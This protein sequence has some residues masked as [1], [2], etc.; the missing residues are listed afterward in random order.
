RGITMVRSKELSEA[1]KK[2]IVDAYESDLEKAYDKV[3]REE[4]WYCMRK[5]GVAEKHIT[6]SFLSR[7]FDVFLG[8]P[9]MIETLSLLSLNTS[10][11]NW[12]LDF[13]TGRPQP[14][15]IGNSV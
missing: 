8:L 7:H 4:L 15:P 11:C 3:P 12:I 13:L 5:S 2:K 10:L 1:F 14:V 9:H 6:L